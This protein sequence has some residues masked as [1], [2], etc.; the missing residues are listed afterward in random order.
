MPFSH[1]ASCSPIIQESGKPLIKS[2]KPKKTL[3][4]A[5]FG[6]TCFSVEDLH[7]IIREWNIL[8]PR[9]SDKIILESKR[10]STK[11]LYAAISAKMTNT[12]CKTEYCW[13]KKKMPERLSKKLIENF[14]PEMP[15]NWHRNNT[16]WL[17]T[18]D[19]NDVMHQYEDEFSNFKFLG[20]VPIDFDKELAPDSCVSNNVC[21]LNLKKMKTTNITK[22]GIVFNL[23]PH[24]KPG[25]HWIAMFIDLDLMKIG[26]WDSYAFEP[27][28][29][30]IALISR[31]QSQAKKYW[32]RHMDVV[33][34]KIR[35]QYK[36]SECGMYCIYFIS[37]LLDGN[38]F[39]A[40]YNN[41]IRDDQMN[42]KRSLFF[43]VAK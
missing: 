23:D 31:M 9:S 29:E 21:K 30:V 10:P 35:H 37:Q 28:A 27:P 16:E 17:S 2:K 39:E 24:N 38:T 42:Q 32:N 14:R 15:E 3:K 26:F 11:E 20:A 34:N 33:R 19:I 8:H 18:S 43:S 7:K 1:K 12:D 13:V 22:I 6:G 25:T 4:K 5:A 41:I 36:N 40:V